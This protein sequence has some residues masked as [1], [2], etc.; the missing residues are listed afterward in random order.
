MHGKNVYYEKNYRWL[1]KSDLRF[2]FEILRF[3]PQMVSIARSGP[4]Q[5]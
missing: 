1:L 3:T 5:S 4:G 2:E